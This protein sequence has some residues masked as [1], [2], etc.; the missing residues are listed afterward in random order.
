M[1]GWTAVA[2]A[3]RQRDRPAHTVF[4]P[5][6]YEQEFEDVFEHRRMP[7]DPTIYCCAQEVAHGIRGWADHEPLF[8]MVNAPSGVTVPRD[9]AEGIRKRLVDKHCLGDVDRFVWERSP[10]DLARRFPGSDGSLYG[11]ASHGWRAA[12]R[13]P[14]NRVHGVR[15]L[16]LASGSAHPGGG[17][18]LAIQS[19][20]EA[21]RLA[22]R[23]R[24]AQ[25]AA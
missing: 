12:F 24:R 15:G 13:R 21:A 14:P 18:P 2:R 5:A 7:H 17:V 8:V 19:G 10:A 22:L 16:Y 3:R 23:E 1:S 20:R 4:F 11:A 9:F 6:R 25:G